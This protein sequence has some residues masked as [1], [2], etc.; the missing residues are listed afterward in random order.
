M[1]LVIPILVEKRAE[2]PKMP[3]KIRKGPPVPEITGPPMAS[4]DVVFGIFRIP[5]FGNL[6]E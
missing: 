2:I 1:A 5:N 4:S 3:V 6:T